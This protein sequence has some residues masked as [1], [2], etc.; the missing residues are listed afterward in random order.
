MIAPA[1]QPSFT[2]ATPARHPA[3]SRA[4]TLIELLVVIAIIAIL[5]AMLL[6]ALSKAKTKAQG[7]SC[8][9]NLKQLQLAWAMYPDD[10]AQKLVPNGDGFGS[11][12]WVDGW[13]KTARDATNVTLLTSP[14]GLLWE[15]NKSFG[16]YKCPADQSTVKFGATAHPRVRSISMN[17]S[18][19]GTGWYND[20]IRNTFFT[21]RK[22]SDIARPS[23]AQA[24]VFVDEH[25]DEIDDGYFLV[26]LELKGAWANLPA[27]YHSG[28]C[29]FSFADGHAETKKW[30]DP[31]TLS[32]RVVPNAQGPNDVPWVQVRASAPQN[33]ATPWP[34]P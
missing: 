18:M 23:P 25:P 34:P 8:L 11:P 31:H 1:V 19:N 24:F 5:A 12:G 13:L 9:N 30:R 27:N 20:R 14:K 10:H 28:A 22:L 32:P 33:P 2:A 7:I 3:R 15:Y 21:F 17:G 4:F 16:I 29:G 26:A 6:P